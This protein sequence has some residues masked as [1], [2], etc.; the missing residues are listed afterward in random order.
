MTGWQ[1]AKL[2]PPQEHITLQLHMEKLSLK[3]MW[4]STEQLFYN[5][6]YKE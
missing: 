2:T 4:A 5:E 1:D 6:G 3:S